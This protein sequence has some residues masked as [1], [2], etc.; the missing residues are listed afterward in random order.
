MNLSLLH[1][2]HILGS[3]LNTENII[4]ALLSEDGQFYLITE[5][6][7]FYLQEDVIIGD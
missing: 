2:K 4:N 7:Q 1:R 6:E 3:K 5:D